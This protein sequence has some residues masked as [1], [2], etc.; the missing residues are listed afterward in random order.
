MLLNVYN[1]HRDSPSLS[2][3]VRLSCVI[4]RSRLF[5]PRGVTCT[6]WCQHFHGCQL[7][8]E[9]MLLAQLAGNLIPNSPLHITDMKSC[10]SNRRR[11]PLP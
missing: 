8:A 11:E 3:Y 10:W 6:D 2:I 1:F 9:E 7:T 5:C 4:L